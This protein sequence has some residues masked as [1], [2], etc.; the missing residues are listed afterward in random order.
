M[1]MITTDYHTHNS[2]CGH[3]QGQIEDYI[4]SALNKGLTEIGISDHAPAYWL[5]GN[6][7]LPTICMAK[8]ELEGYVEEVLRL[9]EKYTG[10]IAVKLGVEADYIE[11]MEE[12]YAQI[13]NTYPFD[14]V[15]GSVHHV[16]SENVFERRRWQSRVDPLTVYQE[17]Y[18]LVAK[19]AHSGLFN[20]VAH[21]S[22]ILAYAPQPF[23]AA[24]ADLQEDAVE[25]I[26]GADIAFEVNTSGFRKMHSDPFP[27]E[28][29]VERIV[30]AG[31]PVTFSS[32]CHRPDEVAYARDKIETL[33]TRL[34]V[35]EIA[36]FAQRQR[37]MIPLVATTVY[38]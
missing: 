12:T 26:K 28:T 34:G 23:P 38:C 35:T 19:S 17:Y 20:I 24:L 8:D 14:Y 16:S 7:P 27:N 1:S 9:K 18:R 2:R 22:A 6:D 3:A 11:G 5:D 29:M 10:Q 25:Q 36:T 15:I 37:I 31:F 21:A 30:E 4:K 33:F 13:L 32:D